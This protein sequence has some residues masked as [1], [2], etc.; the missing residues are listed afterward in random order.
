MIHLALWIASF[1]F[2]CYLGLLLISWLVSIIASISDAR[3]LRKQRLQEESKNHKSEH[4]PVHICDF[5][6]DRVKFLH[7]HKKAAED[8]A[9]AARHMAN[10]RS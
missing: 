8:M 2:L 9:Y 3:F 7:N 1:L 6:T 5:E 10:L 4:R